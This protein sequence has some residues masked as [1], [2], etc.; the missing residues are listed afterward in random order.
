MTL[1]RFGAV[2]AACA[3]A[4]AGALAAPASARAD[5]PAAYVALGDSYT[6]APLVLPLS[7]APLDCFQSQRNYPHLAAAALGLS[8]DDVSCAG[9]DTGDL[10]TAQFGDQPAQFDALTP[11]TQVVTVG[12]G[13]NDNS[14]FLTALGGC[15]G[16]DLVAG[17]NSGSLCRLAFGDTFADNIAAD[18]ANVEGALQRVHQLSPSARVFVVGYP[19]ILPQSG[20]CFSSI[21]VTTG[22]VAYLNGVEL[23]LNAML[24]GAAQGGGATFVDTYAGSV[25]HDACRAEGTRWVEPLLPATDAFSVHP[26]ADGQ[27]ADAAAVEAAIG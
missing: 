21:P 16:I 25:G 11:S 27:A 17:Q 13:G 8:L 1:R 7:S 12:I 23:D 10:S 20:S 18:R 5:A 19:D 3:A 9:A 14:T 22:D 26:N 15:A 2:L 6:S 4:L 24:R